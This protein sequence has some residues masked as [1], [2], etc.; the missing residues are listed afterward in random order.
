LSEIDLE[1]ELNDD[2][3][4]TEDIEVLDGLGSSGGLRF[5]S[6]AEMEDKEEEE[7][8]EE[9]EDGGGEACGAAVVGGGFGGGC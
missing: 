1:L 9:E 8:E 5:E 2:G 4:A 7:E 3:A 6:A